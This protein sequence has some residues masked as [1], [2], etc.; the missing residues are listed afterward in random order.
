MPDPGKNIIFH[1]YTQYTPTPTTNKTD[2]MKLKKKD[3]KTKTKL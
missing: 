3:A 1:L 2:I